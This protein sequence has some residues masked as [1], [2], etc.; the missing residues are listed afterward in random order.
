MF[1]NVAALNIG[2]KHTTFSEWLAQRDEGF[3][4]PDRPALK[5]MTKINMTPFTDAQRKRI[6]PKP[7]KKP[8]LFPP[9]IRRMKEIVPQK[10][11]AKIGDWWQNANL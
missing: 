6:Q 8:K 5:G 10:Y 9:T 2:M 7:V 4:L 11:V 3:L 1:L